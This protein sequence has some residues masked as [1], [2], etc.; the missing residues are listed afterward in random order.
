MQVTTGKRQAGQ[1]D[2]VHAALLAGDDG[3]WEVKRMVGPEVCGE[4]AD[5]LAVGGRA[6]CRLQGLGDL[7]RGGDAAT[8]GHEKF[9]W[10]GG[11]QSVESREKSR[12]IK[13]AR[14]IPF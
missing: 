11:C 7:V 10:A 1:P 14:L 12:I 4:R 8:C 6:G 13:G 5:L 9:G 3:G 2:E